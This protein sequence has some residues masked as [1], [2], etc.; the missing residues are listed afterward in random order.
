MKNRK[1]KKEIAKQNMKKNLRTG[2]IIFLLVVLVVMAAFTV[3]YYLYTTGNR[4]TVYPNSPLTK[5]MDEPYSYVED[6]TL[7][8]PLQCPT[9]PVLLSV[10]GVERSFSDIG[11]A[12]RYN[13]D[14]SI[15]IY[16]ISTTAYDI[17][18]TCFAPDLYNGTVSGETSYIPNTDMFD[19]GYFNSYPA[20]YQCGYV[21]VYEPDGVTIYNQIYVLTLVLDMGFDKDL[22]ITVS[23]TDEKA[24]YDAEVLLESVGY[25]VVD[26][27][28]TLDYSAEDTL[29]DEIISIT[30]TDE[31]Q[32]EVI[33]KVNTAPSVIDVMVPILDD[34]KGRGYVV[35]QYTNLDADTSNIYL[36]EPNGK[37]SYAN[38]SIVPGVLVYCMDNPKSG[39]FTVKIP[40]GVD[41]GTYTTVAYNRQD[42]ESSIYMSALPTADGLEQTQDSE[43]QQTTQESTVVVE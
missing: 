3:S 17:L 22:M 4:G 5:R 19:V 14:L 41:L 20:E 39:N 9:I 35:V 8:V 2:F 1:S 7:D 38:S 6:A 10:G 34:I 25:T 33:E 32:E 13:E 31:L 43:A 30:G 28:L 15:S 18:S 42:F 29:E 12:F 26:G 27:S 24:L 21:N 11:C 36:Y 40:S 23:S 16:E 37:T